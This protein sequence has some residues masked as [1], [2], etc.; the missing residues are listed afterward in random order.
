VGSIGD[1]AVLELQQGDFIFVDAV[2]NQIHAGQR[3]ATRLAVK[4]GRRWRHIPAL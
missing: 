3:L 4:E 1:A 2:G